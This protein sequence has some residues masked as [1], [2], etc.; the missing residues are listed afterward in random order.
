MH[1]AVTFG[2]GQVIQVLFTNNR[3][4][5]SKT[6][7]L[8]IWISLLRFVIYKQQKASTRIIWVGWVDG[9]AGIRLLECLHTLVHNISKV[10]QD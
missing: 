7:L 3:K 9:T 4:L 6:L 10:L 1:F 5:A 2:D 8:M